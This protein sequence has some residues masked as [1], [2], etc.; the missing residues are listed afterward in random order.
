MKNE[1]LQIDDIDRMILDIIQ[2]GFPLV[3]H[4]YAVIGEMVGVSEDEAL[5]RVNSMR[6]KKIIRRIGA[7]FNAQRLNWVTTLCAARV[8]AERID[9]FVAVVNGYPGVTHNY[10]RTHIYNIWFTLVSP[11]REHESV[12]LTEISHKT[13]ISILNLPATK[14]YKVRVDFKMS[15][16]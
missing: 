6:N 10:Q 7:N 2:T 8:P 16:I 14:L 4:P 11:S 3:S 1:K 13:G 5:D 9:N 15:K 12:V